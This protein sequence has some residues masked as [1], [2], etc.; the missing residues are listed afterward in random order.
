VCPDVSIE[1]SAFIFSGSGVSE[2]SAL[3]RGPESSAAP[4]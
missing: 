4:L 2:E 3:S 1:C